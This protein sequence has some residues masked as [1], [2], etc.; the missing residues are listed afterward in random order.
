MYLLIILRVDRKKNT[1]EARRDSETSHKQN[2]IALAD[3]QI[4]TEIVGAHELRSR[5]PALQRFPVAK[6]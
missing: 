4:R 1:S 5:C 2:Y 3:A 6:L